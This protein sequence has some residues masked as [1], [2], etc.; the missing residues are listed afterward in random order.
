MRSA[1]PLP[2]DRGA[3]CGELHERVGLKGARR[4]PARPTRPARCCCPRSWPRWLASA[5]ERRDPADLGRD[6]PRAD[7]RRA[8]QPWPRAWETSRDAVVFGSFSKYFSMTGWRIGWLLVPDDLLDARSTSWSATSPSARRRSPSMRRSRRS[9][10]RVRR[11][12]R[13]R[14]PAT[15]SNRAL[16]LDGAPPIGIDRAGAGRRRVLRLRRRRP[17][18]PTT[19]WPGAT[20][21][22]TE[23]GVAMA[24][25]I[26]FDTAGRTP[27]RTAVLRRLRRRDRARSRPPLHGPAIGFLG[28]LEVHD[29]S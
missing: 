24:P 19:P 15:P 20:G 25:G 7:L 1:E 10:G 28:P 11:A 5:Q 16:L 14:A 6:L 8:R 29:F 23:T 22:S 18:A 4:W 3:G 21:C 27:L 12:R 9:P 17:T 26:D 13:P 2:A